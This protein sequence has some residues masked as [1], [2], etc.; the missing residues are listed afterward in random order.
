MSLPD[1]LS[2]SRVLRAALTWQPADEY[3]LYLAERDLFFAE[4][5]AR[6]AE[7][8]PLQG[9]FKDYKRAF[10]RHR[11]TYS[12]YMYSYE[13]WRLDEAQRDQFIS[14]SQM[15]CIYRKAGDADVRRIFRDKTLFLHAFQPFIHRKWAE[16]AKMR[17]LIMKSRWK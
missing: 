6:F 16:V 14:T 10:R 1:I 2:K 12:E 15:Q 13:F 9:S 8:K 11:V 17:F 3:R 7:E 4:A 5:K